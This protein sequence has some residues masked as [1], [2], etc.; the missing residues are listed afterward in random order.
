MIH[1]LASSNDLLQEVILFYCII[2]QDT[3][4]FLLLLDRQT[5]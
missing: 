4:T 5:Y 1:Y 2:F 3:A